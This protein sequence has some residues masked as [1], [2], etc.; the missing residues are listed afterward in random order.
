MARPSDY[1]EQILIKAYDYANGGYEKSG[2]VVP[3]V[4]GLACEI[5][6]C[7]D[8]CYD[9][10]KDPE[11]AEFSYIV[12]QV[13]QFQERKLVNGSLKGDYNALIAKLMLSK[14]GYADAVKQEMSGSIDVNAMSDEQLNTRIAEIMTANGR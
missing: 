11:K 5:G 1:S 8:T 7:R 4:A 6:V 2:D 13:M 3:T 14:H 12:K 9:W 10:S